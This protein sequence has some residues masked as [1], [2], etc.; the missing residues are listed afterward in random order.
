MW[1]QVWKWKSLSRVQLFVTPWTVQSVEFSRPE[2][3]SVKSFLSTG[4]LANLGFPHCRWVLFQLSHQGSPGGMIWENS[5]RNVYYQML[6]RWECKF[7]AWCGALKAGGAL[8]QSGGRGGPGLGC[9]GWGT[10]APVADHVDVWQKPPQCCK[11]II[12]QLRWIN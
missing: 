7:D 5:I 8:E 10:C 11:V 2:Y 9:S 6:N 12:L 3:W 4:N 1:E